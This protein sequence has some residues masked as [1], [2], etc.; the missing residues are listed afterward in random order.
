MSGPI[1]P[2]RFL[3]AMLE[4]DDPPQELRE[5]L[6]RLDCSADLGAVWLGEPRCLGSART[7]IAA[8]A[9]ITWPDSQEIPSCARDALGVLGVCV[10]W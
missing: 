10:R 7:A 4:H 1:D 5:W 9:W 8:A 3:D 6:G 2:W